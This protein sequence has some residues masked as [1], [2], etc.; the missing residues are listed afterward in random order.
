M[1]CAIVLLHTNAATQSV[2]GAYV[3]DFESSEKLVVLSRAQLT[4]II[5]GRLAH[6]TQLGKRGHFELSYTLTRNP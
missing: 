5:Y 3:S 2:A 6:M 1:Q 4:R